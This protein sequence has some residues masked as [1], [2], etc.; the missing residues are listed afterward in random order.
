[1]GRGGHQYQFDL[2]IKQCP[3]GHIGDI[4]VVCL[5]E[6]LPQYREENNLGA[7][8]IHTLFV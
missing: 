2:E 5:A 8:T 4:A 1:M 7:P 6:F 3:D